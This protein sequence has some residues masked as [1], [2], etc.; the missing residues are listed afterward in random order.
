V[1]DA[2]LARAKVGG[3]ALTP[4]EREAL[5]AASAGVSVGYRLADLHASRRPDGKVVVTGRAVRADGVAAPGVVLLSYRL[6][7]T[8]TDASGKP[9]AGATVVTRTTDRD[10]WTFSLPSNADGRYVSFF[11]ASDEA[12]SDPVPLNVQIASGRT[13]YSAGVTNASFK[14]LSSATMNVKLPAS[15]ASIP[16]PTS[17]AGG[18][19]FY[20]GMLVGVS[21]PKGVVKPLSATWPDARGRFSLTLPKLAAGTSLRFWED[22]FVTFSRVVAHPGGPVDL[23][24]WPRALTKRVSSGIAAIRVGR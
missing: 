9:V 19:A 18:G 14:R 10:F 8:I 2:D 12:G 6:E 4:A 22:D 1:Q 15:G 17:T 3:R 16:V 21:G 23:A 24:T 20:R 5:G 13:S 11:S 7:G